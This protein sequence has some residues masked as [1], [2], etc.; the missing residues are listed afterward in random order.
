MND[1]DSEQQMVANVASQL[2]SDI[3]AEI[4]DALM[5][6]MNK[7]ASDEMAVHIEHLEQL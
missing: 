2:V 5:D 4:M 1:S 3:D 6:M 7:T